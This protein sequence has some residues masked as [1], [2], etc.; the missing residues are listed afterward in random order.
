VGYLKFRQ[1]R[2]KCAEKYG[3][4]FDVVAFHEAILKIGPAPFSLLEE[5]LLQ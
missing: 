3:D 1:L 5:E 4:R 2:E